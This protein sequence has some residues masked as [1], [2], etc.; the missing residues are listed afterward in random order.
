MNL[1]FW[2]R[3]PLQASPQ[4]TLGHNDILIL[5]TRF[6]VLFLGLSLVLFL[7]GSNYQN[8]LILMLAFLM[9]SLF[10][11]CLLICY[12]NLAGV[13]LSPQPAPGTHAGDP[14]RFPISLSGTGHSYHLQLGFVQGDKQLLHTLSA[15]PSRLEVAWPSRRRGPL[16]PPPLII[17]S[18]YPLGLCRVWSRL[19][20]NQAAWVW[21]RPLAGDTPQAHRPRQEQGDKHQSNSNDFDGLKPWQRGHSLGRV[22][23]KQLAQQ[24]GMLVKQ[25]DSPGPNPELLTVD[26]RHP[27]LEHHLSELAGRLH[28]LHQQGVPVGL[29]TDTETLMPALGRTHLHHCLTLLARVEPHAS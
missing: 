3:P 1:K 8:N 2:Q 23:W 27:Q 16:L 6:G 26:N 18:R 24:R 19:A 15:T 10:S 12:R 9:V 5:P 29:S 25:F 21:P 4:R 14:A 22:A 7:F 11:S 17:S 20:L 28:R 13:T